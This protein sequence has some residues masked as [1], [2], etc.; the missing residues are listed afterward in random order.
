MA[1]PETRR[2]VVLAVRSEDAQER[3]RALETLAAAYWRP[4]FRHLRGRWRARDEE[5]EDLTQGFFATAFE[6]DFFTALRSGAG[7]LPHVPA[8]LPRRLT[9]RTE[10]KA[11][12]AAEARRRRHARP[13]RLRRSRARAAAAGA[14]TRSTTSTPTSTASGCVA[15]SRPRSSTLRMPARHA[16]A[17][18]ASPRFERYDLAGRRAEPPTYDELARDSVCRDARDQRARRGAARVPPARARGAARAVRDRRGVRG[19]TSRALTG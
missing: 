9:S 19:R 5:A 18:S 17:R 16:G 6:K 4:V 13:D 8:H 2:S 14:E 3:A 12:R 7:A 15:C 10:R 11:G 1:F